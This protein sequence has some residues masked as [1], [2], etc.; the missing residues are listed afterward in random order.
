M[1]SIHIVC[2]C[3]WM[4]IISISMVVYLNLKAT[5]Q[6][7]LFL[8]MFLHVEHSS[9]CRFRVWIESLERISPKICITK[10]KKLNSTETSDQTFRNFF[11]STT[12]LFTGYDW[13][14]SKIKIKIKTNTRRI[15]TNH[16]GLCTECAELFPMQTT[17]K[18]THSCSS[19]SL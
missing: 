12:E 3:V 11:K 17:H 14:W 6:L 18:H 8:D 2:V 7:G 5:A 19:C 1:Q 9:A 16:N 13:Y 10:K 4:C 15:K